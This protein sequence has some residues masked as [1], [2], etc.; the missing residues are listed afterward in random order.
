[1]AKIAKRGNLEHFRA[2]LGQEWIAYLW[3]KVDRR[4]WSS[5]EARIMLQIWRNKFKS[6]KIREEQETWNII[7]N[8]I[9]NLIQPY[10]SQNIIQTNL[11]LSYPILIL[12]Y[13]NSS[14]KGKLF[15]Y[16]D[17]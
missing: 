15:S 13:L 6:K 1:M 9:Q 17:T 12:F 7:P 8:I 5:K 10:L 4:I 3:S 11:I 2:V 14:C 16:E